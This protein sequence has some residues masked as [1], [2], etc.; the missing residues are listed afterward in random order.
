MNYSK[1]EKPKSNVE[2]IRLKETKIFRVKKA[3][4]HAFYINPDKAKQQN[5]WKGTFGQGQAL[6]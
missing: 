1:L 6:K 2:V 5:S 3:E 4:M